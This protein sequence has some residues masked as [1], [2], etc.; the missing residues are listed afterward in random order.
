MKAIEILKAFVKGEID[1][2]RTGIAEA[3]AI[4]VQ[5]WEKYFGARW[6]NGSIEPRKTY[7][8][9]YLDFDEDIP[10]LG[11]PDVYLE[12]TFAKGTVKLWKLDN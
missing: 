12:T 9:C 1:H 3:D 11:Y 6:K 2:E 7:F 8:Y 10:S 4:I 5:G